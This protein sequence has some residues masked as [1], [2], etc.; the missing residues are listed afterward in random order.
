MET[1]VGIFR[2]RA[3]AEQAVKQLYA[4]GITHNRVG[5]LTPGTSEKKIESSVPVTDAEPPG[6]GKALLQNSPTRY[7]FVDN[8]ATM[9]AT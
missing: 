5:L 1:V 7:W 9:V 8:H 2:S 3:G 4:A 6:I